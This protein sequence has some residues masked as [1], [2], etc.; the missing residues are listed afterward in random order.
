MANRK[1]AKVAVI[2]GEDEMNSGTFVVKD[3]E[4]VKQYE[5]DEANLLNCISEILEEECDHHHE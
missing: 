2:I 5:S 1:F 4:H 3:L